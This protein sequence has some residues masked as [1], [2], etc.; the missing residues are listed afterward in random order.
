ML[1]KGDTRHGAG[2]D[3]MRSVGETAEGLSPSRRIRRETG[4]GDG[5]Q[6]TA[7]G[8]PGKRRAQMPG[9][10][11]GR[12]AIDVGDSREGRIHQDDAGAQA[13]VQMIVD[14]CCVEGCDEAPWEKVTQKV[15]AGLGEFVQRETSAS[16]LGED[17]EKPGPGGRLEDEVTRSDLRCRHC[18]QPHGQR[19]RELLE[20]LHFLRAP[21]MRRQEARH[22]GE[23]RQQCRGRARPGQKRTAELPQEEDQRHLAR[24]I[25]ELPVPGAIGIGAAKGALHF[26]AQTQRVGLEALSEIGLQRFGDGKDCRR[27]FSGRNGNGRRNR[28]EIGHRE[29]PE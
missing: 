14:L 23:D 2:E 15:G 27:G 17:R 24:L 20:A 16:D 25:G 21:G 7:E 12:P 26:E 10:R 6:T 5:D 9:R 8:E 29:T 11:L 1:G 18:S 19:R 28:R 13:R 3:Q 4:A 22:L